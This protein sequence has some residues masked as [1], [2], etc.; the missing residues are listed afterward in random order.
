M[1]VITII[2]D[3]IDS[4]KLLEKFLLRH[5]YTVNVFSNAETFLN[6]P[7][8]QSD[9]YLID[10]NLGGI[11]GDELCSR[12]KKENPTLPPVIIISAHPEIERISKNACAEAFLTK[13]FS[14]DALLQQIES[15][16]PR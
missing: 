13:P 5:G 3:D 4:R 9:L 12:M 6:T 7:N 14:R 8:H 1:T 2:D 15:V 10:I 11:S 16:L